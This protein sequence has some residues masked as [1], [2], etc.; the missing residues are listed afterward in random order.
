[1]NLYV[2]CLVSLLVAPHG[3]AGYERKAF[4]LALETVDSL[5]ADF[6]IFVRGIHDQARRLKVEA[7]G[8]DC[9]QFSSM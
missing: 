4:D 9:L 3:V 2:V 1:M 7:Y 5:Q 6:L 8:S